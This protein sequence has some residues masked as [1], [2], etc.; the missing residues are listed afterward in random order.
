MIP[1]IHSMPV[2]FALARCLLHVSPSICRPNPPYLLLLSR[3]YCFRSAKFFFPG[4]IGIV[5]YHYLRFLCEFFNLFLLSIA[6]ELGGLDREPPISAF[7][8]LS[9]F[10]R[11]HVVFD[12]FIDVIHRARSPSAMR[13]RTSAERT[14]PR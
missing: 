1:S 8:N 12:Y 11:F 6:H 2:V 4:V 14:Q 5:Y 3:L 10:P 7:H 13:S 9:Y